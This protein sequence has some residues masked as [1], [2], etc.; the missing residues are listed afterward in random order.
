MFVKFSFLI[1]A[2]LIK[3]TWQLDISEIRK[4]TDSFVNALLQCYDVPGLTLAVV[5]DDQVGLLIYNITINMK[6]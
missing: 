5:K 2:L 6:K 3:Q 1:I 4:K